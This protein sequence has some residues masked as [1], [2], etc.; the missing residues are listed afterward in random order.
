MNIAVT[1]TGG[2]VGQSIIKAL[3]GSDYKIIAFD[4]SKYA[5]GLHMADK[6]FLIPQASD[7]NYIPDLLLICKKEKVDLLFPGMDCELEKLS[8]YKQILKD[9]GITIVISSP[10]IVRL[11]DDKYATNQIIYRLGLPTIKTNRLNALVKVWRIGYPQIIKPQKGGARSK[12]VYK[13]SKQDD[14]PGIDLRDYILQEYIEGDEYTCG[15]LTLDGKYRG[16]IVMRRILRDGD[17]YKAFVERNTVIEDLCEKVCT[18]LKPFGAFNIQLRMREGK[19]YVF[20]FNARC[21]G[22]TAARALAGFN[23]PKMIADYLLKGIEPEY[24]IKEITI[25]RYWNELIV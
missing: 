3:K 8:K 9:F 13:I 4:S 6:Y 25:L 1:A 7:D 16:C 17:T 10:E 20:E 24:S 19:P 12:N 21:S 5:A 15:T 18:K 2:G 22:T 14:I 11:A 23:E